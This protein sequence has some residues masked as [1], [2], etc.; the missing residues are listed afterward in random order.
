[1]RA[2][3]SK[4]V[5]RS[6]LFWSNLILFVFC[7]IVTLLVIVYLGVDLILDY[8]RIKLFVVIGGLFVLFLLTTLYTV[9]VKQNQIIML[10]EYSGQT[11]I[12]DL[13]AFDENSHN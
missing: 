6:F 1:M 4:S 8:N 12:K 5:L 3:P 9:V 13:E 11:H 10:L 2:F 7:V